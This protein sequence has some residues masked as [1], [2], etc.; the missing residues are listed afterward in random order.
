MLWLVTA[1]IIP[2]VGHFLPIGNVTVASISKSSELSM[3]AIGRFVRERRKANGFTQTQ[4]GALAGTG[5]RLISEIER[6]KPTVRVD[7]L[8]RVLETFGKTLAVADLPKEARQ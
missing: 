1:A 8:N 6:G 7:A 4:L 3:Q 5:T 2:R